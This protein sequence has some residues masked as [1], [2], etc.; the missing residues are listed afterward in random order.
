M[1]IK[2][3]REFITKLEKEGELIRVTEE[4]D[5]D[6]EVGAIVRHASETEQ[7]AAL[8][9]NIKDYPGQRILGGMLASFKRVAI[10]MELPPETPLPVLFEE[11][12]KRTRNTIKPRVVKD[13]PCQQ[14]IVTGKDIDLTMFP[15]PMVH[16]GDGGRYLST[17]HFIVTKDLET[18]W[19]NWGMY[20]QMIHNEH[21]MGGLML[22]IQD[23]GRMRVKYDAKNLPMPFATVIGADP[24]SSIAGT[25]RAGI[26]VDEADIAGGLLQE[27]LE[28]VKCK[29]SDIMVPAS[30][31]IVIEGH[32][33]P[34]VFVD[35]GPFGEFSGYRSS[36]R[37]PRAVYKV[38]AITWRN[39]PIVT[40]S[41]MG[42]PIDEGQI[43]YATVGLSITIKRLLEANHYPITGVYV[44]P[45]GT[46]L[47]VIV[48]VRKTFDT[49]ITMMANLINGSVEGMGPHFIIFVDETVDPYDINKVMHAMATKL[50]PKTGITTYPGYG[51]PLAPFLS[52][53]ER[54]Q[55]IGTV[56]V[57]DCTWPVAWDPENEKPTLSSFRGIYSEELQ[58]KVLQKWTKYGF[59]A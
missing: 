29:T 11:F 6:R 36:P 15:A 23:I 13:A 7:P 20:R 17:W 27:P 46:G 40:M 31:E 55:Q 30:S 22:P 19:Q 49:M 57:L 52:L 5:W 59:K 21:L 10:A 25:Y 42:V 35:E 1:A 43:T 53:K 48:G 54:T 28:M 38:E 50:H 58:N 32:V 8:F 33:V 16:D 56:L 41:N 45:E 44:P 47:M 12:Y 51:V 14:N 26:G 24:L 3:N 37:A 4:V 34:D 9:N 18:P 39:D 2:D